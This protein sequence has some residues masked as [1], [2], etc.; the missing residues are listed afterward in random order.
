MALAD[1]VDLSRDLDFVDRCAAAAATTTIA[2]TGDPGPTG[3]GGWAAAHA[4][5]LAASPG[6]A[7]AYGSALIAGVRRP[8]RDPAVI[9]D[10]SIIAA[11]TALLTDPTA[12]S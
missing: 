2:G 7:D 1:L 8:G 5:Q 6:F 9:T 3:P 4:W 11:V 12:A 10:P